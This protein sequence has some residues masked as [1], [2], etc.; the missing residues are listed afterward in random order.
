MRTV[1]AIIVA[2]TLASGTFAPS[3]AS[4]QAAKPASV[5]GDWDASYNTPGGTTQFQITFV[6]TGDKL[7]GTVKRSSGPV[8]L[9]G[10][11]K[12][13]SVIFSYDIQYNDH[14]LSMSIAAKVSG[15]AMKGTVDF[16]GQGQDAFEAKR[17]SAAPKKPDAMSSTGP[18]GRH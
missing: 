11:V 5:A 16:A 13:D 8:A 4:A 18:A 2:S 3:S 14:P 9:Q 10:I 12:G 6:V 1:A 15:D 7:S 17:A